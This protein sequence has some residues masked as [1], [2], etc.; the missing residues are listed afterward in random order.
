MAI[1]TLPQV[2][3]SVCDADPGSPEFV[4]HFAD[5]VAAVARHLGLDTA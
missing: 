5:Q 3:E 4:E 1:T 2:I